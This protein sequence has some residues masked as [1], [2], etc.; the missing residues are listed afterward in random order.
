[1]FD[2]GI[3]IIIRADVCDPCVTLNINRLRVI[4]AL[5]TCA[6]LAQFVLV[7]RFTGAAAVG[8]ASGFKYCTCALTMLGSKSDD[9][10]VESKGKQFRSNDVLPTLLKRSTTRC[11]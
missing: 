4:V 8:L 6:R 11:A 9:V 1:M 7:T 5:V 3:S 2:L 10:S